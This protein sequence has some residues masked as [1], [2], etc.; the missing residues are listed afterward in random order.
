[1]VHGAIGSTVRASLVLL[2]QQS[3]YFCTSKASKLITEILD[4]MVHGAI[5]SVVRAHFA[6]IFHHCSRSSIR[7]HTYAYV[8][9]RQQTSAYV[10]YRGREVVHWRNEMPDEYQG[11]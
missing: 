6:F 1:M 10:L 9:I 3:K 11:I 8:C 2:Y 4:H 5:G 7:Q